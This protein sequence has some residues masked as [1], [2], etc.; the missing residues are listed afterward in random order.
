MMNGQAALILRHLHRLAPENVLGKLRDGELLD[1]FT[2]DHD[3]AAFEMLVER[4][5][6]MVL[7]VCNRV[8]QNRH[9]AE[10]AFQATFL[11][12]LRKARS[13]KKRDLLANWLYGVAYR[14]ALRARTDAF[15]R[16]VKEAGCAA[17]PADDVLNQVTGRELCRVLDEE[18]LRLPES[19]RVPF[20]LCYEEGQT[21]EEAARQLGCSLTTLKRRLEQGRELMRSRLARRGLSLSGVLVAAG[22]SQNGA[23]AAVPVLLLVATT[24]L[25]HCLGAGGSGA[26]GEVSAKVIALAE[27]LLK[28]MLATKIKLASV[29][30][31]SMAVLVAGAG[32]LAHQMHAAG[33]PD[34][35]GPQEA[36]APPQEKVTPKAIA[37]K[38][39]RLDFQGDPL[40]EGSFLR[41][42]SARL[43]H[44]HQITS[45]AYV[46]GGKT[47]VST[48]TDH[49]ARL[50]DTA[51]GKEIR[52][53]GEESAR[54]NPFAPSRWVYCV[55]ISPDG[56]T[57]ATGDH[58][59]G[60]ALN[61]IRLWDVET[62]KELRKIQ[63]HKGG[64]LTLAFS[65]N[66]KTLASGS[67]DKS[68]QL[69]QVS[70]GDS[71]QP[72]TGNL[73]EVRFVS[74]AKDGAVL[75]NSDGKAIRRWELASNKELPPLTGHD[76]DITTGALSPD[77]K[78]LATAD[79]GGAIRLWDIATS[80]ELRILTA[81]KKT[82]KS[83]AFS[84]DSKTL[85]SG[86]DDQMVHVWD[87]DTGKTWPE[88]RKQLGP[89]QALAFSPNRTTLAS[90]CLTSPIHFWEVSTGKE[91]LQQPGHE[92]AV[93]ALTFAPD[94]KS[95]AS[96]S[97][98]WSVR[99]WDVSTGKEVKRLNGNWAIALS[100]DGKSEFSAGDDGIIR[101]IELD[102]GKEVRQYKGHTGR[103][104]QLALSADGR[105]LASKSLDKT[106]RIWDVESAKEMHKLDEASSAKKIALSPNGKIL[107]IGG[108]L[109]SLRL[110]DPATK[111]ELHQIT[112]A[113]HVF[114]SFTFSP[115]GKFLATGDQQGTVVVWEASSAKQ[116]HEFR[117]H[118]GYV[119]GLAF[120]PDSRTVAVGSWGSIRLWEMA[121]GKERVHYRGLAGDVW[122][123]AF[124]NDNRLVSAGCGDT[125]IVVW[126]L[127]GQALA[128]PTK[129]TVLSTKELDALWDDL[130][131]P[132]AAQA[133]RAVGKLVDA[134]EQAAALLAK[135]L[136]SSAP[137]DAKMIAQLIKDLDSDDFDTR[138]KASTELEKLGEAAEPALRETYKNLQSA[139]V[140][141][142]LEVLLAK[143]DGSTP[144][145]AGLR[146]AR[147][148]E[149]L[150]R[151]NNPEARDVL[152]ALAQGA[153]DSRLT[154]DAKAVLDRLAK[155]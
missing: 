26:G 85:A 108:G 99:R 15:K 150:E 102:S 51:T 1:R 46:P 12:F 96:A 70:T 89:I 125:T 68:V 67:A 91:L 81:H 3:Q 4:H 110:V 93:V 79:A 61:T 94:G 143:L 130:A 54:S 43:R 124:S 121:S 133:F 16:H 13:L 136:H 139:E 56:K 37:A 10:D 7:R 23:P 117:G 47:L 80:K 76:N 131:N 92:D 97:R 50:W 135:Q 104:E 42:G 36:T 129:K 84:P 119:F 142:R 151:V 116:V 52:A 75:L 48:G 41:I 145:A 63:G 146:I 22:L 11:V 69:W 6:P 49:V 137:A 100:E 109:P 107:A 33:S 152:K 62:G 65:P 24:R 103:V 134:P 44:G 127:T 153:S 2:R 34:A 88:P 57:L 120:S 105:T 82:V 86:G 141:L 72:F 118:L 9:A 140:H 66:G 5:G 17:N 114:E 30:L 39:K 45:L 64:I 59:A 20:L 78:V 106:I 98:D 74:F 14:L 25:N 126:D 113:Q 149:I 111:Q 71:V 19:L 90:A 55:A 123:I 18:L 138:D 53:F 32:A 132:D 147:S 60:W 112:F 95:V 21:R 73:G 87:V 148:L 154:Q 35:L 28:T 83:V 40:P 122:P 31:L 8:L 155:K 27:G 128:G 29:L 77:G 115:D 144:S 101:L 38:E 58:T